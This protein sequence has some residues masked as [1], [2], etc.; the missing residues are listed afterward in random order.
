MASLV[1]IFMINLLPLRSSNLFTHFL[2]F[3]ILLS[4][5]CLI[6]CVF[7]FPF[8]FAS[9]SLR[10]GL[11]LLIIIFHDSNKTNLKEA[12][13]KKRLI[14]KEKNIILIKIWENVKKTNWL[15]EVIR[16]IEEQ[17]GTRLT[18]EQ[19]PKFRNYLG[20]LTSKT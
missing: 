16:Q 7:F 18:Q 13:R 12:D 19:F 1:H 15:N 2:Y 10:E 5:F 9:S 8:L 20:N 14:S 6:G 4:Y 3:V 11:N 17:T